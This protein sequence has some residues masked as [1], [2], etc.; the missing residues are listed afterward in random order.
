MAAGRGWRRRALRLLTAGGGVLLTRFPFWHCFSGLLLCAERADGRRCG[1]RE[2]GSGEGE[3]SR[4]GPSGDGVGR[5]L[6][7]GHLFGGEGECG[8]GDVW[9]NCG[10]AAG[11]W[12]KQ[13]AWGGCGASGGYG[14]GCEVG[15]GRCDQVW[16]SQGRLNMGM[17]ECGAGGVGLGEVRSLGWVGGIWGT[18]GSLW[19]SWVQ[20][21]WHRSGRGGIGLSVG[22][23]GGTGIGV[24]R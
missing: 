5:G 7:V 4:G 20:G 9:V 6:S 11:N 1:G 21:S 16:G 24:G 18:L 23:L 15:G 10:S 13:G 22:E 14:G 8:C 19:G 3:M 17:V 2:R 12:G